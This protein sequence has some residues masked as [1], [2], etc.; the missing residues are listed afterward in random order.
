MLSNDVIQASVS[1]WASP[2]VL[3]SKKDGK[4]Q[5]CIDFRKLN[6]GTNKDSYPLTRTDDTLDRLQGTKYFSTLNL[7]SGYWQCEIH[8]S[9]REKTAFVAY[10]GLYEFKGLPFRLCNAP[11]TFQH[12]M[13][14]VIRDLNWNVCV[15]YL[16]DIIVFSRTFEEYLEHLSAVFDRFREADILLKPSKCTF[17]QSKVTYL[18]HIISRD[19]IQRDPEK[20]RLVQEFP[21][22]RTVKH[23]RSFLGLAGYYRR[24]VQDFAKIASPLNALTRK[25]SVFSCD[26]LCQQAFETLKQF[27]TQAP[28]LTYPNYNLPFY[29]HVDARAEALGSTLG[30]K[31]DDRE[32]VIAYGGPKLSPQERNYSA[33]ERE[34]LIVL[35]GIKHFRTYLYGGKFFI[36]TDHHSLWWLM[37]IK[38]STGWLA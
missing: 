19:G 4:K 10:G 13:E 36:V 31:I 2:V 37:N 38:K 33:T 5:F 21:V 9:S 14:S 12:L 28:I 20:V 26:S 32:V 29:L 30:Q 27:L 7:M 11:S 35:E 18:G 3:V 25:T 15:I 1:P 23:V 17:G 6:A 34:A 8:E 16:D 24:F 22:P